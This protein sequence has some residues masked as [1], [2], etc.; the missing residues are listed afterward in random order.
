MENKKNTVLLTVI[1]V[2]TLLVAVVGATFAYFSAQGG[3]SANAAVT[4]TTGSAAQAD[5]GTFSAINIYADQTNFGKDLGTAEGYD[6]NTTGTSK[7]TVSWT[8]PGAAGD[9]TPSEAD[10]SFCYTAELT[11]T[12]NTFAYSAAN[13]TS[14]PEIVFTAT[15]NS[16]EIIT[17]K[18]IT[19]GTS[20]VK[21]PVSS[22]EP[23]NFTHKLVAEAG[24]NKTD[25]WDLTV[26]LLNYDFDQNDNTGKQFAGQ[27]TF[28]KV[29]CE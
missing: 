29:N 12:T 5:F 8:A 25:S 21:I 3:A 26:S 17:K 16:T 6:V 23:T 15:K 19:V 28:T 9:Q 22:D 7:G 20:S 27:V 2:A 24:A 18:D 13:T 11:V 4:V 14:K 1:A 10:R